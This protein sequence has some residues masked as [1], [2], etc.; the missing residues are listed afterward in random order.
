MKKTS[1]LIT[2]ILVTILCLGIL[3]VTLAAP[4]APTLP[5]SFYGMILFV[6]GDGEPGEGDFVDAYVPGATE[7]VSRKAITSDG[8]D[9]VYAINVLGDDPDTPG[10]KEG[11]LENE[12]ITFKIGTRTVATGV[13][14]EG[15]NAYLDLHP[16]QAL[17]VGDY[18]GN[19]NSPIALSGSANDMG[20]DVISYFWSN[21]GSYNL[22]GQN[23]SVTYSCGEYE[24]CGGN[25]QWYL[26]VTDSQGGEG[27]K[28]FW[29][30][31]NNTPWAYDQSVSTEED[32][33]VDITLEGFDPENGYN[34]AYEIVSNPAHG[35]LSG[36]APNVTYTPD[37]DYV[38][39]D[40]FTFRTSDDKNAK[41]N[42]KT[43]SITVTSLNDDPI[44][45]P[46]GNKSVDELV[47]LAFTATATDIDLPAD[48]LTFSLEGSPAGAN[49]SSGGAF[50][51]TPSEIQG[52]GIYTFTVKVCDSGTPVL[53]DS[54]VITVTVNEVNLAPIL[55]P[56]GDQTTEEMS[57]LNFNATATDNDFPINTK[58]FSLVG[59]PAGATITSGGYFS[60]TPTMD[61]GGADYI[62]T[63]KVCDNGSPVLCDE[64]E[65]TVTVT[66]KYHL[67]S[68]NLVEGWNLV[69]FN[70][71][72]EDDS[73]ATVL[74]DID[75]SYDL[76]YAWDATGASSTSG[77]WLK[78]DNVP[79]SPDT[80]LY[81]N[82]TIGF[83]IHMTEANTLDVY[84]YPPPSSTNI[85]LLDN[86]GGW[87]LVGYPGSG[88]L[89]LP[90]A[91]EE[92]GVTNFSLVYAYDVT[93]I[94]DP[95]KLFDISA[96]G[97][98]ND[99]TTMKPGWGYWIFVLN[100]QTWNVPY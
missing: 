31:V 8:G 1:L 52:P 77:N 63:V 67:F 88:N 76:V 29:V 68:I 20:M 37:T 97:Y 7:Y 2:L 51:W 4:A 84:G 22:T 53:C 28:I 78:Y 26:K 12:T 80:L 59:G 46:I 93:D 100:D 43:V 13:W 56:I 40:S 83:W 57:E 96:P 82:E 18:Y 34:I 3:N 45:N 55:S 74:A 32:T 72:P 58:T 75:G 87:N 61:Q 10:I 30:H 71:H 9:L 89:A 16:P 23:P 44:L 36:T 35:E 62:F 92:H 42:V 49:I 66:E 69:S 60:W 90:G 6:S 41:S 47:E 50:T 19:T 27:I 86:V 64:E 39:A 33:P 38:G 94:A 81:L 14:Q 11:G 17:T 73:T 91:L 79:A 48:S 99:L 24:A 54:E 15:T 5:S 21:Y 70:V 85:D 25:F 65:I 95:W 98:V